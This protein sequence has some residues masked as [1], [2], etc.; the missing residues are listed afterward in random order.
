MEEAFGCIWT[1][2]YIYFSVVKKLL[3]LGLPPLLKVS[4]LIGV[5]IGVL[6]GIVLMFIIISIIVR[7]S[8][9]SPGTPVPP[10][11]DKS[12]ENSDH[13]NPDLIPNSQSKGNTR[14]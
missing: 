7:H 10:K 4:P 2:Y 5:V 11:D 14:I 3:F 8:F 1:W 9:Y 13:N 12:P 6:L